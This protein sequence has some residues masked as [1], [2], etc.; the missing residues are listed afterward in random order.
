MDFIMQV[1]KRNLEKYNYNYVFEQNEK[2][3]YYLEFYNLPIDLD[4]ELVKAHYS[5]TIEVDEKINNHTVKERKYKKE[6]ICSS[7]ILDNGCRTIH[8]DLLPE[9]YSIK[10]NIIGSIL[11]KYYH[12]NLKI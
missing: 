3:L 12:N 8:I 1:F 6:Y 10:M 4:L 2:G 5:K 7:E 9:D 11:M